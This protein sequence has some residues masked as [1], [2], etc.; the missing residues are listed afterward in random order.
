[1]NSSF[2]IKSLLI[3]G[4]IGFFGIAEL[5]RFHNTGIKEILVFSWD[6]KK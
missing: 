6:D 5:M 4:S 1:M 2:F 3:T